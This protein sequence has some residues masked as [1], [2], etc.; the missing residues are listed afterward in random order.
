MQRSELDRDR[1]FSVLSGNGLR[2]WPSGLNPTSPETD[3]DEV[4]PKGVGY[5]LL[6]SDQS[7]LLEIVEPDK[8]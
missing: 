2:T 1:A 4:A 5:F 7:F 3:H 6:Y 8:N